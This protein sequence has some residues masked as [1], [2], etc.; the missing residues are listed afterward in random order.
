MLRYRKI[1]EQKQ[2]VNPNVNLEMRINYSTESR[3][4]NSNLNIKKAT[5][6]GIVKRKF[7]FQFPLLTSNLVAERAGFVLVQNDVVR[8]ELI[9]GDVGVHLLSHGSREALGAS[10]SH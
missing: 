6:Q 9:G 1:S 10:G 4:L 7:E 3:N 2:Q 5:K 8:S